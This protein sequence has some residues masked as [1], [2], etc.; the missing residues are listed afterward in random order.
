NLNQRTLARLTECNLG[1]KNVSLGNLRLFGAD[2]PGGLFPGQCSHQPVP[3]L[4]TL[5]PDATAGRCGSAL[6]M[7]LPVLGFCGGRS[8]VSTCARSET[9]A[10]FRPP[11]GDRRHPVHSL[12]LYIYFP[13]AVF[14]PR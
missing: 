3:S 4:R 13:A 9:A 2:Q 6:R 10:R 12:S 5:P 14:L 11:R 7:D 1:P 8:L